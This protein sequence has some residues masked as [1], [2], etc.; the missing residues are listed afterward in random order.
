MDSVGMG[1]YLY[2]CTKTQVRSGLEY[3]KPLM[4]AYVHGGLNS[5]WSR[6]RESKRA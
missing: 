2:P 3:S 4:D 1:R 5:R 6:Y